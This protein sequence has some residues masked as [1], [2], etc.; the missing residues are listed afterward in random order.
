MPRRLT[1]SLDEGL[2][3]ALREAPAR[4]R[5]PKSSSDSERLRDYARRGYEAALEEERL[6]TYRRWARE[7][8]MLEI[9]RAASRRA[10]ERRL[11]ED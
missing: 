2:E 10:A 8:E 1:I 7:P 9:P 4:L 6:A 5:L 3:L 11:F